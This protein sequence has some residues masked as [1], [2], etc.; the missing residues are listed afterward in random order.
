MQERKEKL[1]FQNKR[2]QLMDDE[3]YM[4]FQQCRSTNFLTRGR[5]DFCNWLH[6]KQN[7]FNKN[8]LNLFAYLLRVILSQIVEKALRH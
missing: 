7:S 1:E 6:I 2:T 3:E 4:Q 8:D 5:K